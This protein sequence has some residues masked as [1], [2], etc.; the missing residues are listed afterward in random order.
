MKATASPGETQGGFSEI[1]AKV[2]TGGGGSAGSEG[3]CGHP[4]HILKAL[5][6]GGEGYREGHLVYV[7]SGQLL[8]HTPPAHSFCICSRYI[9]DYGD[10]PF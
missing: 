1:A 6:G 3:G 5:F 10:V 7:S 8:T 4:S 2:A 9:C